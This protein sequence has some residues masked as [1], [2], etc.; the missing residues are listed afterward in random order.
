MSPGAL[1]WLRV[2]VA[3]GASGGAL[4]L[5]QHELL[6]S[7]VPAESSGGASE[8]LRLVVA[9]GC[10]AMWDPRVGAGEGGCVFSDCLIQWFCIILLYDK[11]L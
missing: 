10:L 4:Q 11:L 3:R 7:G 2:G 5:L 9:A 8:L 6:C 1:W